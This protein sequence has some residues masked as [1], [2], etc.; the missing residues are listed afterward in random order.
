MNKLKI[1]GK[2]K[3]ECRAKDGAFK[4]TT[5]WIDN[6]ITNAGKAQLALLAGD[7]GAT[8][9]TYLA[10]GTSN[11]AFAASQTAL[12]AEIV[13][14]GLERASAT[15]SRV[16]TTVTDD[17]LQLTK[18]WT[19]TGTKAVEEIGILNASSEG[20]LL[21]R[22]LTTTKNVVNGDLLTGTYQVKFA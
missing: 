9:F 15:V 12:V 7:A 1:H 14:S 2:I 3:L 11:T 10:V 6:G 16:T 5:G 22:A 8:P 18:S 19:P 13:D 20:V 4:W 21:G 17:T